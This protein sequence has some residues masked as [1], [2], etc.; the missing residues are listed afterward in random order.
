M[1]C[2]SRDLLRLRE[3][4]LLQVSNLRGADQLLHLYMLLPPPAAAAA[5]PYT[6]AATG[7]AAGRKGEIVLRDISVGLL[8]GVSS[9]S[10][11]G[12]V[13]EIVVL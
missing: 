13:L 5:A 2:S 12:F 7:G 9:R 3:E 4:T 10:L 6:A 1:L 8:S 11:N